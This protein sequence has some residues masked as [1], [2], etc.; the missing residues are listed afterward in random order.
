M[1]SI[2]G[3]G[4]SQPGTTHLGVVGHCKY[5]QG[6][7]RGICPGWCKAQEKVRPVLSLY[8]KFEKDYYDF[9]SQ[10]KGDQRPCLD[11][12]DENSFFIQRSD[13]VKEQGVKNLWD[14]T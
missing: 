7:Y 1:L 2:N 8:R 10:A 4:Y 14:N 11:L 13:E 6:T 5:L 12:S 3:G 9:G